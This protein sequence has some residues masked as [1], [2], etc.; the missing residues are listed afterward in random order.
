MY[1]YQATVVDFHDGDTL[2]LAVDLGCDVTISLAIRLNG[3][4]A[5]ELNTDE[6]KAAKAYVADW[7]AKNA[8]N[9]VVLNTIKDHREKYGRYLGVIHA[10]SR[11]LND[12]LIADGH[13]KPWDGKGVRPV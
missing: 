3:L 8:P 2:R 6:G 1:E 4:N 7:L 9:G 13:A 5:P 12:D 10:N 11:C